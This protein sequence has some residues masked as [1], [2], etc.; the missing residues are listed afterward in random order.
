MTIARRNRRYFLSKRLVYLQI[1]SQNTLA[2]RF[3]SEDMEIYANTVARQHAQH[4]SALEDELEKDQKNLDELYKAFEIYNASVIE[5]LLG[6]GPPPERHLRPYHIVSLNIRI[7]THQV[8][9]MRAA[10]RFDYW[11]NILDDW[12]HVTSELN[13]KL[14]SLAEEIFKTQAELG[15]SGD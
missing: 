7:L 4:Y 12:Q 5:W 2:K 15:L 1:K 11:D 13:A 14:N 10:A 6:D 9:M 8:K 3:K